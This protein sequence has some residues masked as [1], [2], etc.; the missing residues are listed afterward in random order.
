[1]SFSYTLSTV[2]MLSY[3][4][5]RET[6]QIGH[7]LDQYN[8]NKENV[9]NLG[10]ILHVALFTHNAIII[11]KDGMLCACVWPLNKHLAAELEIWLQICIK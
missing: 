6:F 5:F 3:M 9:F 7:D 11:Q 8:A 1:M 10:D 4:N 2:H